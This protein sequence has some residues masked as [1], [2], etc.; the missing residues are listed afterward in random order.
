M[1]RSKLTVPPFNILYVSEYSNGERRGR[2]QRRPHSAELLE[3][4]VGCGSIFLDRDE[5]ATE[6]EEVVKLLLGGLRGETSDVDGV[7]SSGGGSRHVDG[8]D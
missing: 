6:R 1:T 4:D 2:S 5:F 3:S 8:D 7:A